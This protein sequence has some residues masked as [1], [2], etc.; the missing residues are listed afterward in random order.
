M[1]VL[2]HQS[3]YWYRDL[4]GTLHFCLITKGKVPGCIRKLAETVVGENALD[5]QKEAW[6]LFPYCRTAI[7]HPRFQCFEIVIES[8]HLDD[9]GDN[10]AP[11][12][13]CISSFLFLNGKPVTYSRLDKDCQFINIATDPA[14]I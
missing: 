10:T 13:L 8:Q 5:L 1:S 14:L 3:L 7:T 4:S 12:N 11:E 2:S 9:R 6:N